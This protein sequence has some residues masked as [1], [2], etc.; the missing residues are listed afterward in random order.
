[1]VFFISAALWVFCCRQRFKC[2]RCVGNIQVRGPAA[3]TD[4]TCDLSQWNH[5]TDRKGIEDVVLKGAWQTGIVSF[6]FC[7]R[8]H[9]EQRKT[10]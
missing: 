3:G 1:M 6:V 4:T 7:H 2:R 9:E 10:V 8:S 5:C